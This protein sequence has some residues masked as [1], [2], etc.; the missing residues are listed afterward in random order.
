MT[1]PRL[2]SPA[3]LAAIIF[4][5]QAAFA[6]QDRADVKEQARVDDAVV[7]ALRFLSDEQDLEGSWKAGTYGDSTATT[8]LAV[9]A[10]MAAGHVPGEGPYGNQINRGIRWVLAQQQPNGMLVGKGRSHGPMYSHGISSLMLAEVFGMIGEEGLSS[11]VKRGLEDA[12]RLILKA[13]EHRKEPN[14]RGGWRYSPNS[15]DSDLSVTAW[16]LLALRAAKDAGCDVPAE[17]IDDAILYVRRLRV[18]GNRGFGYQAGHGSTAT[19]AGTGILALEVC[20]D[21]HSEE[22][23][24][25]ADQLL[26][27]PLNRNDGYFFYGAYYCTV[28]MFKVGGPRWERIKPV[29]Y[30]SILGSQLANG[31]WHARNGS[32]RKAGPNYATSMAVLALAVEYRFL[33]IYQR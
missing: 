23:L 31:S 12:I 32:E 16:Q 5:P 33:P 4:A 10:F 8:S 29:L 15:H 2:L 18:P 30:D 6:F 19:R 25:A 17:N 21:H 22:V 24:G 3:V 14:H 20:G 11:Q 9:M 28:G 7:R 13:Q 27:R 26:R 1:K